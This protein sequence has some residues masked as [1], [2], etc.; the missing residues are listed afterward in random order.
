MKDLLGGTVPHK[1]D[2]PPRLWPPSAAAG[3]GTSNRCRKGHKV[4]MLC[5]RVWAAH[6]TLGC[7]CCLAWPMHRAQP[8]Y[9]VL[10]QASLNP[11]DTAGVAYV[12]APSPDSAPLRKPSVPPS[13]LTAGSP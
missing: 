6:A 3:C 13:M 10:I 11:S 9:A 12:R 2:Q 5:F 8:R 1:H 4:S 7:M